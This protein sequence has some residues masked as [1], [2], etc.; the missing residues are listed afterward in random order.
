MKKVFQILSMLAF[1]MVL[2]TVGGIERG[3]IGLFE[4][5]ILVTAFLAAWV[6]FCKLGGLFYGR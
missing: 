4:G 2:G 3:N 6:L 1:L 5:G